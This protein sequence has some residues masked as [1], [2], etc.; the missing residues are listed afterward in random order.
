M[1]ALDAELG[2]SPAR[3]SVLATLRYGGPQRLGELARLEGVTQPTMTQSVQRLE[4][5]GLAIRRPDPD[6]GRG[7]VIHL[8]PAG[9]SL[10]RRARARKIRWLGIVLANVP[11]DELRALHHAAA[12]LDEATRRQ[13]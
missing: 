9:R 8:T 1:R 11:D 4:A 10:V 12:A 13:A 7:C 6:D 5:E 2:L 3:F